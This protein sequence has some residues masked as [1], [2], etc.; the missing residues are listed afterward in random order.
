MRIMGLH[1]GNATDPC[2][3]LM[4]GEAAEDYAI[5]I[6]GNGS[7]TGIYSSIKE[8]QSLKIFP[9]STND[10]LFLK[11]LAGQRFETVKMWNL[12]GQKR[13][14]P[15]FLAAHTPQFKPY[16]LQRRRLQISLYYHQE[17]P[18]AKQKAIINSKVM[19]TAFQNSV[20]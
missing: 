10:K 2:D 1:S 4:D 8:S 15:A 13:S 20:I 9:N 19:I 14:L 12:L 17:M 3:T 18:S 11:S 16:M 7:G 5:L 6:L